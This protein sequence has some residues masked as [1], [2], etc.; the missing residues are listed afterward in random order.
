MLA[1]HWDLIWHWEFN[2]NL[3]TTLCAGVQLGF[4]L[5][6]N[7]EPKAATYTLCWCCIWSRFDVDVLTQTWKLHFV[8]ASRWDLICYWKSLLKIGSHYG[9]YTWLFATPT[10]YSSFSLQ[11]LKLPTPR[12]L[13]LLVLVRSVSSPILPSSWQPFST[14][15]TQAPSLTHVCS[16]ISSHP[17]G[18]D[19]LASALHEC[20]G[21]A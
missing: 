1:S 7:F 19:A 10:C 3:E 17:E 12:L 16:S 2:Q 20:M 6:L 18:F 15:L 9:T 8:P 14:A 13:L 4:D 5:M 11:L 21:A